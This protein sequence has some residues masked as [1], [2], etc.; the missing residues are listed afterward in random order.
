MASRLDRIGVCAGVLLLAYPCGGLV[1]QTP[2]KLKLDTGKE[3]FEA[4]C[5]SCDGADGRGQ[6]PAL[7]GFERPDTFPDFTDC[8]GATPEPD[9]QWRSVITDGGP[10][11]GFSQIMPSF[12]DMLT[13]N[14]ISKVMEY[15]RSLCPVKAWPRGNLNLPLAMI[16]EKAY[17]ENEVVISGS[18]N[19]HGAP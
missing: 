1:G 19:A 9:A 8:P 14:Q 4:G 17:P 6:S 5:I 18:Y 10:G 15:L 13:P 2:S 11:R 16:T 12:K 7:Q 3:I